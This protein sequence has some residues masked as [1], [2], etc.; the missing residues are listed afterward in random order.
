MP[1]LVANRVFDLDRDPE[2]CHRS[3]ARSVLVPG[4]LPDVVSNLLRTLARIEK[5][6]PDLGPDLSGL[7]SENGLGVV[8]P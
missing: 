8:W 4:L 5:E 3:G 1:D 6:I 7:L 2:R